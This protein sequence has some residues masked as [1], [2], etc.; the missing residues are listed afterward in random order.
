MIEDVELAE[1]MAHF[2]DSVLESC[3]EIVEVS[4]SCIAENAKIK[5]QFESNKV[6]LEHLRNVVWGD[7]H[8]NY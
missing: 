1:E 7:E 3:N 2:Y 4:L 8:E 5:V 6:E